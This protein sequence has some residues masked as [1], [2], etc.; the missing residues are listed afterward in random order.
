[1]RIQIIS[2]SLH[3]SFRQGVTG[4]AGVG[5]KVVSELALY[6]A[7][8]T[9][10]FVS[11]TYQFL[12]EEQQKKL[13]KET[14]DKCV[15]QTESYLCGGAPRK[16]ACADP[17]FIWCML[18]TAGFPLSLFPDHR[19]LPEL[20]ELLGGASAATSKTLKTVADTEEFKD[21]QS[22]A[23]DATKELTKG[24]KVEVCR[25]C[26]LHSNFHSVFIGTACERLQHVWCHFSVPWRNPHRRV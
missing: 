2:P 18:L 11:N 15:L 24:I 10:Y 22:S 26:I 23:S 9:A 1:M 20:L 17:Q 19:Q 8:N 6:L 25:S 13:A 4:V 7:F 14:V 3:I 5:A 12:T 21:L 16:A